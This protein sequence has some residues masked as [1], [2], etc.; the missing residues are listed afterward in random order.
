MSEKLEWF[1]RGAKAWITLAPDSR[2]KKI[3]RAISKKLSGL[4]DTSFLLRGVKTDVA[5]RKKQYF[6]YIDNGK[7]IL[8]IVT[9]NSEKF[10]ALMLDVFNKLSTDYG[11][12]NLLIVG[13]L[14]ETSKTRVYKDFLFEKRIFLLDNIDDEYQTDLYINAYICTLFPSPEEDASALNDSLSQG[15]I[16]IASKTKNLYNLAE[17]CA[18]YLIYDSYN[19]LYETIISYLNHPSL[20]YEKKKYINENFDAS[21]FESKSE[22]Q[23]DLQSK[24]IQ[25]PEKLQFVFISIDIDNIRDTIQ[26]VDKY[27]DFVDSYLIITSENMYQQFKDIASKYEITVINEN[28]I[29]DEDISTF[30]KR[31]HQTKNW[32][33]RS[34]LLKIDFLQDQF[35]MLDDDNRPLKNIVIDHFIEDG[36]YNAYYYY[37]LLEWHHYTSDYDFG[38]HNTRRLLKNDGLG[39]LSYSSHKP[40][41]INKNIFQE[42]VDKYYA[43]GLEEPI[44][45]WS[46]YFNYAISKYP[47]LFTKKKFDVLN[48]PDHPS[49]WEWAYIPDR[50]NFENYYAKLYTDGIFKGDSNLTAEEKGLLKE[51]ELLPYIQNQNYSQT[52]KPYYEKENAVHGV[53]TFRKDGKQLFCYG[54]PYYF[55]AAQ[56]TLLKIPLNYKALSLGNVGTIQLVYYLDDGLYRHSNIYVASGSYFEGITYFTINASALSKGLFSMLI[57][58]EIDKKCIYGHNSPYMV[59]LMVR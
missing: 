45:E 39:L 9:N 25:K 28:S 2:P 24:K 10:Q 22:I 44:D 38:Q 35:I 33:L 13:R 16:T 17:Q 57:D 51:N 42:V 5:K 14:N 34:S 59:K 26:L 3:I 31:D 12:I 37:D 46:I 15:C 52:L 58:I 18:D 43:I 4:D 47:Y 20:Y 32:I 27:M 1:T 8:Y 36:K 6:K 23:I 55:E 56:G 29:L 30:K 49:S 19:E 7:Y 11:D 21:L 40:Q 48:W 50:Y 53:L 41:I 54:L